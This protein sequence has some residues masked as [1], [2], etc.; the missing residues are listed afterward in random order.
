MRSADEIRKEFAKRGLVINREPLE[1]T[2]DERK[3]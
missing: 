2:E 1:R 3:R